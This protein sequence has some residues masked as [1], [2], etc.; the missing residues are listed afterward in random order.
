VANTPDV[1]EC[2]ACRSQGDT[3]LPIDPWR[4]L[5]VHFGMLLG[6]DDFRIIDAYHRGK[7]WLH[8]A[9]LHREGVVWGLAPSLDTDAGELRTEAGL[10]LDAAG[11]E[12]HLERPAC[13]DL[14]KWFAARAQELLGEEPPADETIML[15]HLEDGGVRLN[16]H[17]RMRFVAC[18]DRQVPAL[19][20]PCD[21]AG[22]TTAYSRVFETVELELVPGLPKHEPPAYPRLRML[23]GL[24]PIDEELDDAADIEQA[25]ADILAASI[26]DRP[27]VL[28]RAFHRFAARDAAAL[29]PARDA[30][31]VLG[32]L[33]ALDPADFVLAELEGLTLRPEDES[34]AFEELAE[35]RWEQRP[36]HVATRP[37]QDL[38]AAAGVVEL[39]QEG[40]P[41]VP[42]GLRILRDSVEITDGTLALEFGAPFDPASLSPE[43]IE[44]SAFIPEV[45]WQPISITGVTPDPATSTK[46]EAQ[47]EG[48]PENLTRLRLRVDGTS[49][50][51]ILAADG[52]PL[53]GADDDPRTPAHAGRDFV[54]MQIRG[55]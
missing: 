26:A 41:L 35:L 9:W 53:A 49:S 34:W 6:V 12:L 15:E 4:S 50:T 10:A 44:L 52:W 46:L 31:G 1:S 29:E 47:H 7:M 32:L 45:G 43:R 11:R 13:I 20:E 19:V 33:P 23:F 40:A 36:T 5:A 30:E 42:E 27:A 8:A 38:L 24:D 3:R 21:G 39:A 48:L 22:Q 14:G 16:A 55:E 54:H 17:V 51:P 28:E 37:M 2:A 18:L 25:W